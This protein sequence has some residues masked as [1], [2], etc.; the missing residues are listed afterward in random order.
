MGKEMKKHALTL[1]ASAL[2][3]SLPMHADG[4]AAG[5]RPA[6][7]NPDANVIH[8]P[9]AVPAG[10]YVV[11]PQHSAL[12]GQLRH[13]GL[14]Y[15]VFRFTRFDARFTY[16]PMT[17]D[18]PNIEVT[19]DPSS[20]DTGVE[21]FDTNL[22]TSDRHFNVAKFAEIKFVSN[23]L[24]RTGGDKGVMSGNI[25][26]LGKTKPLDFDVTFLGMTKGRNG[27]TVGFSAATT[28]LRSDFGFA[29][30]SE[31]LANEVAVNVQVDFVQQRAS[32]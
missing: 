17:P 10:T 12:T 7:S 14:A 6:Q 22:A 1:L 32:R 8:D 20:I 23:S 15:F 26:F 21:G 31:D 13:A 16:D 9:T 5:P 27:A 25:T 29:E 28:I 3:L 30:G 2:L 11:D 19:I 18:T 24:R 4:R